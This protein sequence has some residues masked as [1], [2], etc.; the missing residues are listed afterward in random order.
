MTSDAPREPRTL[1]LAVLALLLVASVYAQVLGGPFLW[2]DRHLIVDSPSVQHLDIVGAFSRPFW[3]EAAG[4]QGNQAYFRPLTTISFA[5][6]HSIHTDNPAG[7]HLTNLVLHLAALALMIGLLRRRGASV[8]LSFALGLLWALLPRST[9]AAAWISGRGDLLAGLLSLAALF[10]YRSGSGPRLALALLLAFAALSAKESGVAAFVALAVLEL[11]V[12]TGADREPKRRLFKLVVIALPLAL[13]VLLRFKAGALAQS[14]GVHLGGSTGRFFTVL[15]ALGRYAFMI[16]DPLQ[17]RSFLGRLG[18]IDGKYVALGA[19]TLAGL[20]ALVIKG[21]RQSSA[22]TRAYLALGGVPLLLV[23][24]LTPLPLLTVAA[25]RYLY[26]PT[27]ALLIALVPWA[28]A[29]ITRRPRLLV[30]L[31][32]MC[33]ACGIRTFDRAAD[34]TDEAAF[35]TEAIQEAEGHA[36]PFSE[37]GSVAYRSGL[38]TEALAL[39]QK[40]IDLD[41]GGSGQALDNAVLM[42]TVS[43]RRELAARLGDALVMRFP[44]RAAYRLRRASV[45]LNAMNIDEARAHAQRVLVL[46]PTLLEA[47]GFLALVAEAERTVGDPAAPVAEAQRIDMRAARF[48]EIAS[49]LRALLSSAAPDELALREGLEFLIARGDPR[50]A[51]PLLDAYA[52]RSEAKDAAP[53]VEALRLRLEAAEAIQ[54]RL[55]RL[56]PASSG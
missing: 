9:E 36:T 20:L 27:A 32:G 5:V 23:L 2:D 52:R 15:E 37:L 31:L 11:G 43:G 35:W 18:H 48:P 4:S 7:Y 34:Y 17:P 38:F 10:V 14:S 49:R 50:V 28:Q 26:L 3:L 56:E 45:A 39:C 42:A 1:L 46:D 53:L 33:G 13:Y 51:Q 29:Q 21:W 55:R 30:A 40:S 12:A 19:L 24:H 41:D 47:K 16:V 6:D 54:K 8:P 44:Q 25:D 22:A